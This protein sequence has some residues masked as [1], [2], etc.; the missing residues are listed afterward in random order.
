[1]DCG[2]RANPASSTNGLST[3]SVAGIE[4]R[5]NLDFHYYWLV[6]KTS[7]LSTVIDSRVK[8][9]LSQYCKRNGLKLGYVIERAIVEQ[10]EDEI[11]LEAYLERK[12]EETISLEALLDTRKARK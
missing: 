4:D 9:A 1:M 8:R 11:D 7:P 6:A 5:H 10:L 2:Q 3:S 12:N